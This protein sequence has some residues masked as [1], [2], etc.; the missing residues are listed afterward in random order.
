[1]MSRYALGWNAG[2]GWAHRTHIIERCSG[3]MKRRKNS[4]QPLPEHAKQPSESGRPGRWGKGGKAVGAPHARRIGN[5]R[6]H[7][8]YRTR[9]GTLWARVC[10]REVSG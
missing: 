2:E 8:T 4:R 5:G 9:R 7:D 6:A 10:T 3:A 1:M